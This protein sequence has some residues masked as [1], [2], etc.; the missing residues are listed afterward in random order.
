MP[1]Q[2]QKNVKEP[3]K[4]LEDRGVDTHVVSPYGVHNWT[5]G[6][7]FGDAL[8]PEEVADKIEN[9]IRKDYPELVDEAFS[10]N[11]EDDP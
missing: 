9:R 2:I 6:L 1:T 5:I 10:K 7:W 4:V 11:L 3:I 8:T